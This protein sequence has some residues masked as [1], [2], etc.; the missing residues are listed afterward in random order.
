MKKVNISLE[1][2]V[3]NAMTSIWCKCSEQPYEGGL[4]TSIAKEADSL[5]RSQASTLVRAMVEE[6]LLIREG[7][8]PK[9]IYKWWPDKT[10]P[11]IELA[12]RFTKVLREAAQK[13]NM[14]SKEKKTGKPSLSIFEDKVLVKE[15]R[16][17]G[18]KV[19]CTKEV[20]T[21]IEL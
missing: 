3:L 14:K 17:R 2:R 12:K 16:R 5:S 8:K 11:N 13:M 10:G 19:Q 21:T 18:Y 7:Y 20:T 6:K 4:S 15:L 9:Y 1:V